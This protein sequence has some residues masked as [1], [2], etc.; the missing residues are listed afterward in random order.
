MAAYDHKNQ[1]A[2]RTE[3]KNRKLMTRGLNGIL[4][5]RLR[6]DDAR[7]EIRG[8]LET[9]HVEY[10]RD[11]CSILAMKSTGSREQLV[12][13]L[14]EYNSRKRQARRHFE[15]TQGPINI[16]LP[17]PD[18]RL[19]PPTN[20][21]VLGTLGSRLYSASYAEYLQEFQTSH[22][23]TQNAFNLRYWESLQR[24]AM[25]IEKFWSARPSDYQTN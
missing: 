13:R 15:A 7:G 20:E 24:P 3:L 21:A 19:G 6:K 5:E 2:L 22:G 8:D 4:K 12:R 18:D 14:R 10:M 9:L 25:P 16:G 23:T 11:V 1:V 17:T